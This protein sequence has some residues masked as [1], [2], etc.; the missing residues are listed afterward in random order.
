MSDQSQIARVSEGRV[1][2]LEAAK[3]TLKD[4]KEDDIPGLAA[5]VA[6]HFLF[7]LVPLL[8][9]TAAIATTIGRAY[10][11]VGDVTT[12]IIDWLSGRLP[13]QTAET[14]RPSIESAL[15]T[16]TGSAVSLGA[17]LALIG[18]RNAM[19]ALMKAL[20]VAFD[21]V[22]TRPWWKQQAIAIGLT[23]SLGLAI[24]GSSA[25][26][27][28]GEQIG[29]AIAGPL[30][31]GD[32]F[33]F[34]WLVLRWPLIVVLLVTAFAVLYWAGPNVRASF[35][36]ITP[37]SVVAVILWGLV[38][39]G[40]NIYFRFAGGY[41]GYGPL[42][43]LLAFVF[44]LFLTALAILV[45]GELNAVVAQV[46]DPKTRSDLAE[47]PEKIDE[48]NVALRGAL[49]APAPAAAESSAGPTGRPAGV[50]AVQPTWSEVLKDLPSAERRAREALA[51]EGADDQ[52][53][54]FRSAVT[55]LGVSAAAA[56][57]AAVFGASRRG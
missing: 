8:I 10:E 51:R 11:D 6:Y 1:S 2:V 39:F 43:G 31:L 56:A 35:T 19:G 45:G 23:L 13:P 54:R 38:T 14:L 52:G 4:V 37:G 24:V 41:T 22:E 42:G 18:G 32:A 27:L 44:W 55:A 30:G 17:L 40:L 9:L 57:S 33:A 29:N 49:G 20:N 50:T 3:A 46:K 26:F 36:W 7:S 5:Q 16:Q 34:A 25:F 21:V 53:R 47:H 12:N 48:G 28:L 15:Q